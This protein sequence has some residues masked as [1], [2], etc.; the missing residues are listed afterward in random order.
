[1]NSADTSP[2]RVALI[3]EAFTAAVV[4]GDA[5]GAERVVAEAIAAGM[6]QAAIDDLVIAPAMREVGALWARGEMSIGEEHLATGI[7]FRVLALQ[8]EAFRVAA[9]RASRLVM[10]GAVQ[11]EHHVLGLEMAGDLLARA[12]YDVRLLG[13]DV[14]VAS[15]CELAARH[16]PAV[17]GLT[18]TMPG[19]ARLLPAAIEEIRRGA[20]DVGVLVGGSGVPERLAGPEWLATAGG[21]SEVVETVDAL[22]KRPSLN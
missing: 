8:R 9:D 19:A 5:R 6:G 11:E 17:F 20:P 13:A 2:E 10:L 1:M 16:H 18:V 21:V 22:L 3:A 12:G 15:L 14:P 7:S 4:A